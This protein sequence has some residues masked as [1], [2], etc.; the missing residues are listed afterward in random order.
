MSYHKSPDTRT[1][2]GPPFLYLDF[3][4]SVV[5][6]CTY[7]TFMTHCTIPGNGNSTADL[8]GRASLTICFQCRGRSEGRSKSFITGSV[9][10]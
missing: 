3:F 9:H 2:K 4:A 1:G 6:L 5:C 7:L 8:L 10:W